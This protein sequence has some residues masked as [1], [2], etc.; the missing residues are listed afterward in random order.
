MKQAEEYE[1]KRK[2]RVISEVEKIRQLILVHSAGQV[3]IGVL[4]SMYTL[5]YNIAEERINSA[6]QIEN[7]K[8]RVEILEHKMEQ[9]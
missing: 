7:L 4:S 2:D 1:K 6:D 8:D 9:L 3:Q 5:I